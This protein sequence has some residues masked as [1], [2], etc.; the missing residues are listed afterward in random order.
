MNLE[1]RVNTDSDLDDLTA[2][3]ESV[4]L[5]STPP[6]NATPA[7]FAGGLAATGA[8]TGAAAGGVAY[9]EATD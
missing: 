8:L 2:T 7:A 6:V 4:T 1:R 5:L 9:G 3:A